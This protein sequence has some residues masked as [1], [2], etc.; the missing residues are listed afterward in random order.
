MQVA[1]SPDGKWLAA[2]SQGIVQ[3]FST[4]DW[5][6][7]WKALVDEGLPAGLHVG[8]GFARRHR[9]EGGAE[10][11]IA[12]EPAVVAPFAAVWVL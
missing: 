1:F 3:F 2:G 11:P 7:V 5:K 9:F 6:P 12:Y 8:F 4:A 10:S